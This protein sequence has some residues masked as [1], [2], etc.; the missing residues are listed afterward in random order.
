LGVFKTTTS[1]L[2]LIHS[3]IDA[4]AGKLAAG[5]ALWQTCNDGRPPTRR[6]LSTM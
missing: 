2:A 5:V 6:V 4:E 3:T 1:T